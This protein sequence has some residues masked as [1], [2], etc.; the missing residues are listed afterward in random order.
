MSP[1]RLVDWLLERTAP[2][3]EAGESI[4]GDLREE[5]RRRPRWLRG[6]W[7]LW[8]ACAIAA[9][10][11]AARMLGRDS[12]LAETERRARAG[13]GGDLRHALRLWRRRPGFTA[14]AVATLG[15][16]IG[17]TTAIVS[18]VDRVM[19]RSLPYPD[20]DELVTV[21]N[22]FP[23][24]RGHEVLD[25]YWD[26]VEL[27][28]PEYRDWRD[29]QRAF[30]GVAIYST[31]R[32][33]LTGAGDPALIGFGTASATLFPLLGASASLGRTF[34]ADEEGA[35]GARVAVVSA[36]FWAGRLGVD[37]SALGRVLTV[38]GE[39]YTLV[40]VLPDGFRV[41]SHAGLTV[42]TPDLWVPAGLF[43]DA[44][45]RGHH[46][47]EAI[48]RLRPGVTIEQAEADAGPLLRGGAR[49]TRM[50]VRVLPRQG[51]ETEAARGPLVLLLL[52][53]TLLMAIAGV[54]V[55]TL[56][57]AEGSK[58]RHE[59]AT[60]Q[61][62]GASRWQLARQLAM[63]SGSLGFLG[64]VAGIGIAWLGVPALLS[65]APSELGLPAQVALDWRL[66]IATAL[67]GSGVG[68]VFGVAPGLLVARVRGGTAQQRRT[69][70]HDRT[71]ARAQRALIAT[72]AALSLVLLVGAALLARSLKAME[73]VDP[74]FHHRNVM[75]V[76]L[77]LSGPATQPHLVRRL[78]QE[79]T[80]RLAALPGVEAV[81]GTSAAPFSGEGGSSS[82]EI[83]GRPVAR[84]EKMP[85]AH[86]RT[87]LP[88]YHEL[89]GIPVVAG[90]TIAATDGEGAHRVV[91]IS[92]S[93]A[94]R[95]WPGD[96]PLG[97]YLIRDDERW[98][99]V[100]VVADVL[101]ADLRGEAESSFYFP[102]QQ[103][104]PTRF[105]LLVR[106]TTPVDRLVPAIRAAVAEAAPDVAVGRIDPL[107]RL[108]EESTAG[109]RYRA[110]LVA[111]FGVCSLVLAAVGIFG[112]TT[113]MVSAR[114]RELGIRLA[115]GA[116]QGQLT[117]GVMGTEAW[118]LGVGIVAGLGLSAV[119]V[120]AL[121]GFLFGVSRYDPL[122]FLAAAGLLAATG[123]VASY[124]PARQTS[125]AD[126]LEALRVE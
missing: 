115:L 28:Y 114:R 65:L 5:Y 89:L 118:A 74:G 119:A 77:P 86:R 43:G 20:A 6:I 44:N 76:S 91:V 111:V 103:Q 69:V 49:P 67:F 87:V 18:V 66:L 31:G 38:D 41:R 64:A 8:Q 13:L 84:N 30:K 90:R 79:L 73:A 106:T 113:R 55:A 59:F 45:D 9:G 96:S 116:R 7:Y 14:L 19:I 1:F 72:E 62:L 53:A 71:T 58:R 15:L 85:E 82:F 17:A 83:E 105:W 3:R 34:G 99:I 75:G 25:P 121:D 37:S 78:A 22:T 120:R 52:A 26:R 39:P 2:D 16:G 51:E 125:R 107:G 23:G 98:E 122:A 57:T 95:Y 61:A 56:F 11:L 48:A 46:R 60:R 36:R 108:V 117:R 50:G 27:S 42:E 47:Y 32:A 81:T 12:R 80:D 109:A 33:T 24:W 54:N 104:P 21:W 100:G 126:A 4:R 63:E 102:F 40:G 92:R 97:R 93:L 123:L 68:V 112:L 70:T 110:V 88:G 10:Y 29:G 124:L 101:H 35:G 94:E